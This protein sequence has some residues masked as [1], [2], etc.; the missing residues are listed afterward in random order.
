MHKPVRK[1]FLCK[2]YTVSNL[3]DVWEYDPLDMQSL[4]K[5]NDMHRYILSVI[6]IFSKYLHLVTVNHF[7]VSILFHDDYSRRPVCVRTDKGKQLRNN[8]F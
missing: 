3:I 6:D 2:P 5:Y 7:R 1:R 8:H 4:A